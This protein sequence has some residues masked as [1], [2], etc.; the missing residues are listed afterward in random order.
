M[1]AG[2]FSWTGNIRDTSPLPQA[3][4]SWGTVFHGEETFV[5]PLVEVAMRPRTEVLRG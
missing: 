5:T 3:Y 2:E 1:V 4:M